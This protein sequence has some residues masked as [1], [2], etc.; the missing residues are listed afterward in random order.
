[1]RCLPYSYVVRRSCSIP[2]ILTICADKKRISKAVP[3][4]TIGPPSD[5]LLYYN[6][7]KERSIII[8]SFVYAHLIRMNK[9]MPQLI[10]SFLFFIYIVTT[11]RSP[12]KR[13]IKARDYV[14]EEPYEE[15][16]DE[17]FKL[18]DNDDSG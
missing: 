11:V 12:S 15:E 10:V 1:M 3:S 6:I 9:A 17:D 5:A 13:K 7:G 4:S 16:E 14:S 2:R 8:Y 18:E